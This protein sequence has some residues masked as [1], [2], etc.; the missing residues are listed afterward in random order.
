MFCPTGQIG[1][2]SARAPSTYVAPPM[3]GYKP[4]SS[5]LPLWAKADMAPKSTNEEAINLSGLLS[6]LLDD[7]HQALEL[8]SQ[9]RPTTR[10]AQKQSGSAGRIMPMLSRDFVLRSVCPALFDCR[11]R[12][13]H[14]CERINSQSPVN[15]KTGRDTGPTAYCGVG[16]QANTAE[17]R[18]TD[19]A[20]PRTA[21]R[22]CRSA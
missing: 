8:V 15:A 18:R 9:G 2:H 1:L 6:F 12:L 21:A 11:H 22:A 16:S 10:D 19:L 13:L 14:P 7:T 4:T 5:R 17:A 20:S 3:E